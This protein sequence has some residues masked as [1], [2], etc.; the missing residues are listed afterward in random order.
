MEVLVG[1]Q[2]K[3]DYLIEATWLVPPHA[4]IDLIN[5]SKETIYLTCKDHHI[6]RT[7]IIGRLLSLY[8]LYHLLHA[9]W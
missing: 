4:Y 2:L 7:A 8:C 9:G 6:L 1:A 5:I 3:C